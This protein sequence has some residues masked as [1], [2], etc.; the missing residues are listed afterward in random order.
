MPYR[1]EVL[2]TIRTL[3]V[4][5]NAGTGN[6]SSGDYPE[7]YQPTVQACSMRARLRWGDRLKIQRVWAGIEAGLVKLS[8]Q[9]PHRMIPPLPK[10]A[11]RG[12]S[13]T[14]LRRSRAYLFRGLLQWR[15]G[16]S[17]GNIHEN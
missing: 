14:Y 16:R 17:H 2:P 6:K 12:D 4:E 3:E 5:Q 1:V 15:K 10:G 8:P 7:T 13:G 11:P 9:T